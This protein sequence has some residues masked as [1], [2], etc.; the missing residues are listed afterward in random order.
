M[1]SAI[2]QMHSS[3]PPPVTALRTFFFTISAKE[4]FRSLFD[5][6]FFIAVTL[7]V[8]VRWG[9][10]RVNGTVSIVRV[11]HLHAIILKGGR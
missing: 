5:W 4:V 6:P 7:S 9:A 1:L 2:V 11:P 8:F 3:F 10:E